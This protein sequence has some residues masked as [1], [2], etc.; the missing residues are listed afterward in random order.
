[1]RRNQLALIKTRVAW[2]ESQHPRDARGQFSEK[3]IDEA[4]EALSGLQELDEESGEVITPMLGKGRSLDEIMDS[5][6]MEDMEDRVS[7]L[8]NSMDKISP[9]VKQGDHWSYPLRDAGTPKIVDPATLKPTQAGVVRSIVE[10]YI[11][12]PSKKLPWV[13]KHEGELLLYDGHHRVSAALLLGQKNIKVKLTDFDALSAKQQ[14]R[15]TR[16][17]TRAV[18]LSRAQRAALW[19]EFDTRATKEERDYRQTALVLFHEERARVREVFLEGVPQR[20]VAIVG[21]AKGEDPFIRA[22]LERALREYA[23]GG[24]FHRH[25]LEQ[26]QRLL[27]R[28]M[29]AAAEEIAAA[30]GLDFSLVQPRVLEAVVARAGRLSELVTRETASQVTLVVEQGVEQG[31][32]MRQ[33]ADLIDDT[34]F[35]NQAPMRSTR[36]ARTETVGSLNQ[37]EY[38]SASAAGIFREKEWLS[39]GDDRVRFEHEALDGVRIPMDV[40]FVPGL[41]HPGDQRAEASQI[42]QCRCTLL[43]H[44]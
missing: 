42:I 12:T 18:T 9:P 40:E 39:Q 19:R 3:S 5:S 23:P 15:T 34:V 13:I 25:W 10:K 20:S 4:I 31:L 35:D 1:V 43:Y 32:G 36:I 7:S 26:Y 2:D 17:F 22:A 27:Q 41:L 37:G 44:T 8:T 24:D 6:E 28:T 30:G 38:V 11:R 16:V 33:I 14:G 21:R 29:F